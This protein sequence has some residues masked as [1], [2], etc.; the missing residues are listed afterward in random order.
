VCDDRAGASLWRHELDAEGASQLFKSSLHIV[1]VEDRRDCWARDCE[2]F[3]VG[4][5]A[6]MTDVRRELTLN[7]AATACGGKV[8]AYRIE[9][10]MV[11]I[12][13]PRFRSRQRQDD[14]GQVVVLSWRYYENGSLLGADFAFVTVA[15]KTTVE[16]HAALRGKRKSPRPW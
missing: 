10:N 11:V 13:F 15:V 14:H 1:T 12:M 3:W 6:R 2:E 7:P 16:N 9:F 4:R 5:E 8:A